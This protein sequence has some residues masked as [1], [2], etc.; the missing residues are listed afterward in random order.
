MQ[1]GSISPSTQ[2]K[3]RICAVFVRQNL[4][5]DALDRD[6]QITCMRGAGT[7]F[8]CASESQSH[9][10]R[11]PGN[12]RFRQWWRSGTN[13]QSYEP[14][15]HVR[16]WFP[17]KNFTNT[18]TVQIPAQQAP[19]VSF[20]FFFTEA[21]C[22]CVSSYLHSLDLRGLDN[23]RLCGLDDTMDLDRLPIGE[24]HQRYRWPCG[25]GV[26]CCHRYLEP[27]VTHTVALKHKLFYFNGCKF[28][29][30]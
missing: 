17:A 19:W 7:E 16:R 8:L 21:V 20:F 25:W 14:G 30:F 2:D 27:Q 26:A 6:T 5:V 4:A 28:S 3:N 10:Q 23:R 1:S 12:P 11:T 22:V 13:R 18:Q 29:V 24:L 9:C 15:T